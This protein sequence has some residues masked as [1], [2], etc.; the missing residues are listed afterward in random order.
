MEILLILF[1][2]LMGSV[3][4]G[5]ILGS[6]SGID[7][8]AVGSGNVGATNVAR[9]VGKR[10]GILT[11]IADTAKGFLPVILAMQLG[12]SLAATVLVGAAAFLGH[13]YPIFLKFKGG[14]G[15]ATAL[16]VFLAV[17]PMATLVLVAL[18]AVTVL[19]SRIVSLSSILTAVAAPIIF[20]L[21]SYPPL[22]VGM[23][24]FIALAITCRHRSNIRRMMNGSEPRFGSASSQ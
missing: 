17:A 8:R 15:V 2:Y 12:A 11:L 10:Q 13:L 5:F 18:F 7:V 6:R 23:A 16:G 24:A 22:V 20:W 4:V 21:F 3:P 19:A 1:G 14:K 9:V